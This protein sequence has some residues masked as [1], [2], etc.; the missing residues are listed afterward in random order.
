MM[1][2]SL[3]PS[4]VLSISQVSIINH[5]SRQIIEAQNSLNL[6]PDSLSILCINMPEVK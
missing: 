6:H 5:D 4:P 2:I 1:L 3:A